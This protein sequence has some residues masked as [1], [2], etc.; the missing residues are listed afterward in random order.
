[1]LYFPVVTDLSVSVTMSPDKRILM[2][3]ALVM[4]FY[5]GN[6]KVA[7]TFTSPLVFFFSADPG[8][9]AQGQCPPV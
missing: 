3:V 4:V 7:K 5:H 1:M 6:R 9:W 2:Q 8:G